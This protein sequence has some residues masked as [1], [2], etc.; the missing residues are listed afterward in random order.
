M[1]IHFHLYYA[2]QYGENLF[3][4]TEL[5]RNGNAIQGEHALTYLNDT[6]WHS[7]VELDTKPGDVLRYHYEWHDRFGAIR[8]EGGTREI[9][10]V[11]GSPLEVY[12]YWIPMGAVQNAFEPQAFRVLAAG[13]PKMPE[14]KKSDVWTHIFRVKAP[15][16]EADHVVCLLGHGTGL[17]AWDIKAPLLLH[18]DE[19][20]WSVRL[21]LSGENF[22][23]GYKYGIW[24]TR[25]KEFLG[26]EDGGN[27][28]LYPPAAGTKQVVL[29]DGFA[30]FPIPVWRGAGVAIP[31]FSLRSTRSFGTGE[32]TDLPA[33][34]DWAKSVGLKLIQLL[35]INDTSATGT[36][37][38]SYPYSAISAF[39]LN[40]MYLNV[41]E[42]AGTKHAALVKPFA[43]K[44]QELNAL[45]AVD[46]EAVLQTKWTIIRQLFAVQK[47]DFL[48][49]PAFVR[50]FTENRHW[51]VPYSA[52]CYL[53][54]KHGTVSHGQSSPENSSP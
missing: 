26:F 14:A 11:A 44:Q 9:A 18:P 52:F 35:P 42:V 48:K 7:S 30:R 31:V 23:L 53:R 39:A 22:P 45:P 43:K 41:A 46:Y 37:V 19:F 6:L 13:T 5:H 40:P 16:L 54:D 34:A 33:L 29:H 2:T 32:F 1:K 25:T 49:D 10:P 12:D 21:D 50:Y 3:V 36:W 28:A 17:R 47:D 20:G 4:K 24:N 8:T 51:L 15:L 27:R 38:D